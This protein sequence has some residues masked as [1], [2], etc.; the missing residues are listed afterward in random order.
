MFT[1]TVTPASGKTFINSFTV[2]SN[3]SGEDVK[4]NWGD[5]NIFYPYEHSHIY[6]KPGIYNVTL[7][8]CSGNMYAPVSAY[9]YPDAKLKISSNETRVSAGCDFC[10]AVSLTSDRTTFPILSSITED[11][12]LQ[13]TDS[14]SHSHNNIDKDFYS[15]L[16]PQWYFTDK[17]KN[18]VESYP[19]EMYPLS[20]NNQIIG[21]S[22]TERFCYHDDMPGNPSIKVSMDG[23]NNCNFDFPV[24]QNELYTKTIYELTPLSSYCMAV[25]GDA[26]LSGSDQTSAFAIVTANKANHLSLLGD[27]SYDDARLD[28]LIVNTKIFTPYLSTH[29]PEKY[30]MVVGNHDRANGTLSSYNVLFP[31]FQLYEN[32]TIAG[33]LIDVF[34]IDSGFA[35]N[36][37]QQQPDG[38]S[39]GSKQYNKFVKAVS[40][41]KALIKIAKFHHPAYATNDN[42]NNKPLIFKEMDWK[43]EDFGISL[44]LNGHNHYSEV[45]ERNGIVY[46]NTSAIVRHV[47]TPNYISPYSI[48]RTSTRC[49]GFIYFYPTKFIV[50][51]KDYSGATVFTYEKLLTLTPTI[52][53]V[54]NLSAC[55]TVSLM[56]Y[57]GTFSVTPISSN[58]SNVFFENIT[59][60]DCN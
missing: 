48:Y 34:K 30:T 17:N 57:N 32:K 6:T 14:L 23:K 40:Q 18:I 10:F 5:E 4:I 15:H 27:N 58:A 52:H 53:T 51:L 44:I 12:Y 13:S 16:Q 29:D 22:G 33:G 2:Q 36:G 60:Q 56:E 46:V 37:T 41:S 49:V 19:I 35:T 1:F 7:Q 38:S 8:S 24:T 11:V 59:I 26:G 45:L 39:I 50:K 43:F 55:S 28:R 31:G 47:D 54:E 21:Y 3:L 9:K 25:L 42:H 20:A